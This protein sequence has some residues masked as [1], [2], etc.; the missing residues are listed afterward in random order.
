M[1]TSAPTFRYG[2]APGATDKE[3]A[4]MKYMLLM[5]GTQEN[6][7]SF[8]S[9]PME[10]IQAHVRFM[11]ELNRDLKAS[12]EF[13]DAQGL[14]PAEQAKVVRARSGGSAIVTDGPF[15][16]SKEFLAGYWVLECKSLERAIE[17]AARAS[18]APGRAG[19]P[20]NFPI[21]VRA[22]GQAPEV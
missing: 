20:L 10:D 3:R 9:M 2:S 16:E 21:E 12:G 11:H 19:E 6:F 18:A 17:I 13:V 22:I 1:R 8:G 7:K 5:N 14:S 4:E 15:P